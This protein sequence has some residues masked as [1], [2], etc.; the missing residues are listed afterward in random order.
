MSEYH[1]H[2]SNPYHDIIQEIKQDI[3]QTPAE[4]DEKNQ[5]HTDQSQ[6]PSDSCVASEK[7]SATGIAEFDE[8]LDGGFPKGA[9]VLLAGSSG[10]GKTIFSFQWLF[11]GVKNG[12]NGIYIS[13]TEPL[14]KI[15]QNLEKMSFYDR[16]AVEQESL[17]IVDIR[18]RFSDSD[19][20]PEEIISFIE[21]M[22][23][24]GNVK[25]LCIDSITAVAYHYNEKA[26]IRSFI[27]Q[28]GKMLATLGCTTILTSEVS[29]T[30]EFSI[31]DVEE[32][33]SDAILRL[34][35]TQI[36]DSFQRQLR[37]I[38]VRGKSFQSEVIPMKITNHGLSLFPKIHPPLNYETTTTRLPTGNG[39]L[40][41][42]IQ[43]GVIQH[44]STLLA[45]ST[46]TGKTLLS[47]GFIMEG[48]RNDEHCLFVG[49]EESR[50]KI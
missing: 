9:V 6:M 29:N 39:V 16:I 31:Y 4:T 42:M 24:E 18:D 47:L 21:T 3:Q 45:G 8:I 40:D 36:R 32:F 25:R 37:I 20:D 2:Q 14:F 48:L 26:R 46:G 28:L 30:G 27:F 15:V 1:S 50:D 13:L 10:S 17:K 19:Y 49:F 35:Q 12:E 38:K 41:E 44:S 33:I 5:D 7:N 43:G 23:K 34:D 22:V 11:N